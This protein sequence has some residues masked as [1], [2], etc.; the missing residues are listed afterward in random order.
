MNLLRSLAWRGS[1][2]LQRRAYATGAAAKGGEAGDAAAAEQALAGALERERERGPA[3]AL[4]AKVAAGE[5]EDD[6]RQH[7]AVAALQRL[8][9][10]MVDYTAR[11]VD[12][13]ERRRKDG[14]DD[15]GGGDTAAENREQM[16]WWSKMFDKAI[17][18]TKLGQRRLSEAPRGVF[19]HGAPGG[20][21]RALLGLLHDHLST[22][23]VDGRG[24]A[25][26]VLAKRR[27][28]F[29][30]FM[31]D[32]HER[33]HAIR[34]ADETCDPVPPLVDALAD[35]ALV[36][37]LEDVAVTDVTD[38]MVLRRVFSGLWE[39]G[40]VV[41]CTSSAPAADL[42]TNGISREKFLPF[43]AL[44]QQHCEEVPVDFR[45]Q[46]QREASDDDGDATTTPR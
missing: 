26:C 18:R 40:A 32:V 44:L 21:K 45:D 43:V 35:E 6:A 46:P 34:K 17:G 7:G 2:L 39:H 36:L 14:S 33:L 4:S 41:C 28:P 27:V 37:F 22:P 25:E 15:D 29:A 24:G 10:N 8:D 16:S 20:G 38:A 9:D 3:L 11:L 30:A 31:D 5:L 1:C 12:K 19:L 23:H 13:A 42:Y